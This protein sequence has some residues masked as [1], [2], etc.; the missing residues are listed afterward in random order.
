MQSLKIA[1]PHTQTTSNVKVLRQDRLTISDMRCFLHDETNEWEII[2]YSA[3]G[4][5]VVSTH[6]FPE[7]FEIVNGIIRIE[8][9]EISK[10]SL[11]KVRQEITEKGF[12]TAFEVTSDPL[13]IEKFQVFPEIWKITKS[14][15]REYQRMSTLPKEFVT[16]VFELKHLLEAFE[17]KIAHLEGVQ[18][19]TSQSQIE[20]FES[21]VIDVGG[22]A[23]FE[24]WRGAHDEMAKILKDEPIDVVKMAFEFFRE[25]LKALVYQSPFA[26]RSLQKPLGYA[27]DYEMMNLIYHNENTGKSLFGRCMEKCFQQHAEPQ[28]VRNRVEFLLEK[29]R[30]TMRTKPGKKI[31]ILSVAC[32][33]AMEV[34][35]F[36]EQTPQADLTNVE[37]HLLDQ[38]L[39][40]LKHVQRRLRKIASGLGKKV[41]VKLISTT[42]KN[43]INTGLDHDGYDL[44]YSAGLFDYFTD[45]VA[46]LAATTLFNSLEEGSNL[47]IGNFDVSAP[48]R[49]GMSMVFDW[50]LIYRSNE[51]LLRIFNVPGAQLSIEKEECGVNLFCNISKA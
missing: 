35:K 18:A 27:G 13:S 19:Y 49:F 15:G 45:Q 31:T 46:T 41:E 39:N 48:T 43:L 33:P 30:S 2:D 28:A 40:A 26:N 1:K 37:I 5:A 12:K 10:V 3:F 32:G 42:I 6:E 11:V 44:I 38:D 9:H 34:Q 47:V 22:K 23:I 51:D 24:F 17:K 7:K 20:D 50:N 16:K 14:L 8:S 25:Q 36:I 21:T 29:I 4:I